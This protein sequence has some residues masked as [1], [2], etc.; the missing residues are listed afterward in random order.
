MLLMVNE[1]QSEYGSGVFNN[2]CNFDIVNVNIT[3]GC[4][5]ILKIIENDMN[6]K[7]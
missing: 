3:I 6:K 7:K 4:L 2:I 5:D 1:T